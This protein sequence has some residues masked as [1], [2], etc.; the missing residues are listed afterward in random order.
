MSKVLL[1]LRN[2]PDDEADG[3]RGFLDAHRI[4]WYQTRPGPLG[5]TAGAIW[6]RH[7]EDFAQARRLM[8]AY[9]QQLRERVRAER[10]AAQA[11]GRAET[12]ASML[13]DRPGWVLVRVL[14]I[15]ALLALMALP[16]YLLWR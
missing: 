3:V 1:N 9:Q 10:A 15:V 7:D 2:V 14:A 8:D 12:F 13:R 16:G 5:I 4:A 6:I 11:Q